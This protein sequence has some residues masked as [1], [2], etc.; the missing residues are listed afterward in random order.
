MHII[1]MHCD[2]LLECY[3]RNQRI[4]ENNLSVNL[5]TM[6]KNGVMAQ[7]FAIFLPPEKEEEKG[8]CGT[9]SF[10]LFESICDLYHDEITI[11][12]D[13]IS[14]VL[15][16]EDL[17]ANMKQG[18]MSSLLTVEDGRLLD[19][20][21]DR[22]ESIY[23]R[24]VRLLTLTWN[25]ENC[26]GYPNSADTENHKKGLKPFGVEILERMNDMGMI[27]DV[28]HLS[29][30]GFYDVA[31]YSKKPFIASHSCAR[32]LCNH[33]R[34][35]TDDQLKCIAQAGGVIGVNFYAPFLKEKSAKTYVEDIVRHIRHM[36]SVTGDDYVAFGSDFDGIDCRMEVDAHNLFG[37]VI[38][39]LEKIFNEETVEKICYKNVMRVLKDCL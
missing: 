8:G 21:A 3:R 25:N 7:F 13:M 27:A 29:E 5:Q 28:S 37:D 26:I 23:K 16:Y 34:N 31:R 17:I 18:K 6:K 11:N 33:P 9:D 24:G 19:G 38:A 30:G 35:L 22:L 4:R 12:S 36:V 2:T 10:G 32:S 20:K 15:Q 39:E 1:D 14:P